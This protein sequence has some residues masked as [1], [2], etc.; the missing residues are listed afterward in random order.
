[1]LSFNEAQID[2]LRLLVIEE[3][4][5]IN[6]TNR[7]GSSPFMLL[8]NNNESDSFLTCFNI[9]MERDDLDVNIRNGQGLDASLILCKYNL[10]KSPT[11]LSRN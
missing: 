9:F 1:M 8:C 2:E 4:A 11:T 10:A 6:Y 7:K 5:N 3:N